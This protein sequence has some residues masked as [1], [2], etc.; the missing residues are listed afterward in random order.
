MLL[1]DSHQPVAVKR[2]LKAASFWSAAAEARRSLEWSRALTRGLLLFVLQLASANADDKADYWSFKPA[3]RPA[4]PEVKNPAWVRNPIDRFV[5]ARLEQ[6]KLSPSPEADRRTLI[7]RL[8]FDLSGLPPTPEE[9]E[10]FLSDKRMD[11]YAQLVDRLLSS[12]RYGERWARHWLDVVHYGE[13]HGYDKDKPRL[14]AWPYRD[15]VIRSLNDDK[16]YS[17]FVEEQIAGDV[18]FPDE[19]DGIVATGFI[20][21]GP[22]DFVGHVELPESKTDGLIARYNDRDDMVMTVMSTFQ[23]LTVHCARCHDHKFDPIT[24]KEYYSLQAVFAGVDRADSVYDTNRTAHR[25]RRML[26][27]QKK[28]LDATLQTL[29]NKI[30]QISSP[31]IGRLDA[32]INELNQQLAAL[33][34]ADG[35]KK[36]PSNGYHSAIESV[37]DVIKWVQLDLGKPMPI[38]ELRLIPARPTDFSDTPGFGFPIR[39]RVELSDDSNFA[40][41]KLIADQTSADFANPGDNAVVFKANSEWARFVRITA[42]RLWERTK[43]Y[44]FALGE[45]AV[46]VNG[47]NAAYGTIVTA[48]DSI[49]EGRWS[50]KF[51]VD[52][53]NS[54]QKLDY[55]PPSR[56]ELA[57]RQE[58]EG[59]A[60][61]LK[62][63]RES[64]VDS[65]VDDATRA[66]LALATNRLAEL[67]RKLGELPKPQ[68][69]YAV[70][71][72][73]EPSGSFVPS[74]GPRP[75]YVLARGDVKRPEELAAIGSLSSVPGSSSHF[76]LA[77]SND[78]GSRRAALAKWITNPKNMLTRRSIVN[79]VWQYHFG[80]G[81]VETPNDFGH[82]GALPIHPELLD[83][84]AFWFLDNGESLKKLHRLMVTSATYRQ[85][86]TVTALKGE[87][88]DA[89]Q[90]ADAA[91]ERLNTAVALDADN[92]YL[93][94][95]NRTRLDA[96]SIRDALLFVSG[97]L[98]LTMGG[99]SVQQFYFKDDH[100]PTYDYTRYDL[101]SPGSCRR[102]IYRFIVR[103]VPDPLMD[104]LDCPDASLLTAKRN[105]TTTA[106]QALAIL[107]NPFVVKQAEHFAQRVSNG[108]GDLAKQIDTAYR[109]ALSRPPTPEESKKLVAYGHKHGLTNLCRLIFNSSEFMFVD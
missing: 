37:P 98:D 67:T 5:L 104:A 35:A 102:T 95:M 29:S 7:R 46:Y 15:Y 80:R 77:D 72:N 84:L 55:V 51:L 109:L 75:V 20:A 49:E 107:N 63:E 58:L 16:P 24:R 2:T 52:G 81:L 91:N 43:D 23:S 30:A 47:T 50:K 54:R 92:R 97:K 36:S 78:E 87:N 90:R 34:K 10:D 17:R 28:P 101:D 74:K 106:L 11:A 4:P 38:D 12:P 57:Q 83:W 3:L 70:S 103:S 73:F 108:Q 42:T 71:S 62:R 68:K 48:L 99:P 64:L 88:A 105:T 44:V 79:R 14:N 89:E 82:M 45:L 66:E 33:P 61:K 94:R 96:E 32:R 60:T 93:W 59:Q 8:S 53:Y 1:Q 41:A 9:A 22:W 19:P 85:V 65:L 76:D 100:S 69:V 25:Q 21:A 26:L 18:L 56:A 39:F 31:E 40:S 13:T 27:A 86:S 6:K